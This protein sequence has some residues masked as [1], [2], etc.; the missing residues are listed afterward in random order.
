VA[1]ALLAQGAD[2][3]AKDGFEA[4]PLLLAVANS[5]ISVVQLLL[6][7]GAG[8]NANAHTVV[9]DRHFLG[10]PLH[11]AAQRGD[12][13]MTELLLSNH[14]NVNLENSQG[15]T[16]L[17]H[18]AEAK[19]APVIKALLAAHAD[20]NAGRVDLPISFAAYNGDLPSLGLLLTNGANPKVATAIDFWSQGAFTPL[21]IAISHNHAETARELLRAG[22]DPNE[23]THWG[24]TS[25]PIIFSVL[26]RTNLLEALLAGGADPNQRNHEGTPLL[27]VAADNK[28]QTEIL[29]AHGASVAVTNRDGVMPLHVAASFGKTNVIEA[30]LSHGAD[31]NARDGWGSTPLLRASANGQK[32]TAEL[33]LQRGADPNIRNNAGN[34][35]LDLAKNLPPGG[36]YSGSLPVPGVPGTMAINGAMSSVSSRPPPTLADLLREHGAIENLPHLDRIDVQRSSTGYRGTALTKNPKDWSQFTLLELLAMQYQFLGDSSESGGNR[37]G[38][39][40]QAFIGQFYRWPFPDLAHIK[41]RRPGSDLKHWQEQTIDLNPLFESGDCSK[42]VPLNWGDVVEIPEADHPLNERWQGFSTTELVNLK[43]CLTRHVQIIVKKQGTT[44]TLAPGISNVGETAESAPAA[45]GQPGQSFAERLAALNRQNSGPQIIP[46][47]P[48]WLRPVLLESKL[49][50]A[51]SDLSRVKVTR[52][53]PRTGKKREWVVDCR[54]SSLAPDLWLSDGDVIDVPDRSPENRAEGP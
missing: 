23:L 4:T 14:P 42:D 20:P 43:K 8:I 13:S 32:A 48:F 51:S 19:S 7:R 2:I 16:P 10:G 15:R 31:I 27:A 40:M 5:N 45:T 26:S 41:V 1:E 33:L 38:Y 6:N 49:V 22:A 11:I 17:S 36:F 24:S 25:D 52:N 39:T 3:N 28:D 44:V 50:L 34:T 47:V 53:D 9:N 30:L 35:P 46:Q 37:S 18:A 29:L 12:L 54:E 21:F